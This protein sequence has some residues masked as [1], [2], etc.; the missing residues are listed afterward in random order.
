MSRRRSVSL[1]CSARWET[2]V[3]C[4]A[5][6]PMG[7]GEGQRGAWQRGGFSWALEEGLTLGGCSRRRE[8][9]GPRRGVKCCTVCGSGGSARGWK[10]PVACGAGDR[11]WLCTVYKK[12]VGVRGS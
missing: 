11:D 1:P 5:L 8:Q 12:V 7:H 2:H 4:C 10:W 6:H 9:G 3:E